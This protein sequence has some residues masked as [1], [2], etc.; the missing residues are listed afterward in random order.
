MVPGVLDL[1]AGGLGGEVGGLA[2]DEPARF[3]CPV[4]SLLDL[5]RNK[6]NWQVNLFP[7]SG[8]WILDILNP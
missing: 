4:F 1:A 3:D 7:A 5:F 8:G 2:L 6:K